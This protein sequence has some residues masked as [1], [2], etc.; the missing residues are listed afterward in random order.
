MGSEDIIVG[1]SVDWIDLLR[2]G[3]KWSAVVIA[4]MKLH[5]P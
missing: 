4:V 5:V 1:G 2:V 3:D